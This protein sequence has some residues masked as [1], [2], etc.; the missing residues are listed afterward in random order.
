M[1]FVLARLRPYRRRGQSRRR[2]KYQYWT[3]DAPNGVDL[4]DLDGQSA[5]NMPA[6]GGRTGS[7]GCAA[8]IPSRSRASARRRR[9]LPPI[10]EAP[11]SYVKVRG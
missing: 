1:K 9:V 10:E 4:D 2:R 3:G 6:R 11:G 8:T 5:P 7:N